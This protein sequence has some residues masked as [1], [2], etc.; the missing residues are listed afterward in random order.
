MY[1]IPVLQK[2][3]EEDHHFDASLRYIV[4]T[5]LKKQKPTNQTKKQRRMYNYSYIRGISSK[6]LMYN[7]LTIFNE[8]VL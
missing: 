4:R 5:Y 8:F 1:A 6:I 3:S 2:W 7:M